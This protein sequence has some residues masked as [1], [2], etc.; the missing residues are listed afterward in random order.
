MT[1]SK[2]MALPGFV[3]D[4]SGRQTAFSFEALVLVREECHHPACHASNWVLCHFAFKI[5]FAL[6]CLY[7]DF[8]LADHITW[9]TIQITSQMPS[10]QEE[11]QTPPITTP[12]SNQAEGNFQSLWDESKYSFAT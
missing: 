2:A 7:E 12:P 8:R 10:I 6:L 4:N 3:S 11:P 1:K 9:Q 5:F